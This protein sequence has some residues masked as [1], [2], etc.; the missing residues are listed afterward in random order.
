MIQPN[1]LKIIDQIDPK[2][3]GIQSQLMVEQQQIAPLYL[4]GF[5]AHLAYGVTLGCLVSPFVLAGDKNN[6]KK[7]KTE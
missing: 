6:I 4:F 7:Y 1:L 2:Q 5:I 3:N